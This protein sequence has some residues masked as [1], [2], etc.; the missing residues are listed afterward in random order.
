MK[1]KIKINKFLHLLIILGL[2]V[3][4][5]LLS[6][7]LNING[8][9]GI[10]GNTWDIHWDEESIQVSENSV[11]TE[12][13]TVSNDGQT[14]SYEVTLELPGD[15]Y[16]FTIDAV[17]AGTIDG[18]VAIG[19]LQLTIEDEGGQPTTLPNYIKYSVT[20]ADGS[21]IEK[22]H[23]LAKRVDINTPTREKIKVRIEYDSNSSEL[24]SDNEKLKIKDKLPYTQAD[25]NAKDRDSL[26][27]YT[28]YQNHLGKSSTL[29]P[30]WNYYFKVN[31]QEMYAEKDVYSFIAIENGEELDGYE[32]GYKYDSLEACNTVLESAEQGEGV[33]YSCYKK[34]SKGT[35]ITVPTDVDAC[36]ITSTGETFCY[37]YDNYECNYDENTNDCSSSNSYL[38]QK[39]NEIITKGGFYKP[40]KLSQDPD[41]VI[42]YISTPQEETTSTSIET[43]IPKTLPLDAFMVELLTIEVKE[44]NQTLHVCSYSGEF[45]SFTIIINMMMSNQTDGVTTVFADPET[46]IYCR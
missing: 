33:S 46:R 8:T 3:G 31:M 25:E 24:P 11:Q 13:P 45:N 42:Y 14:V 28:L 22:F 36:M 18:M 32:Y 7:T 20:Y 41:A 34:L 30:T 44:N 37:D 10:K 39:K 16:E 2:T 12:T 5:A 35:K 29:D 9:A 40:V 1:N 21:S 19:G 15:F 4:F 17:N 27:N 6:T 38:L 43:S 26:K 23:K